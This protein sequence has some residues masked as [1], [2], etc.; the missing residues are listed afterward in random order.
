[1]AVCVNCGMS[2]GE[3]T[4]FCP[5]CGSPVG[6]QSETAAPTGVP[7]TRPRTSPQSPTDYSPAGPPAGSQGG[8]SA[9]D[10]AAQ[11]K[12]SIRLGA[13][14]VAI[15]V[16]VILL[17]VLNPFGCG[18]DKSPSANPDVT[19]GSSPAVTE[20]PSQTPTGSSS[21]SASPTPT[22][23]PARDAEV[24]SGADAIVKGI[25]AYFASM[26]VYPPNSTIVPGGS[27]EDYLP[28]SAWPAN[29]YTG[30]AM[31]SGGGFGNFTYTLN[32]DGSDYQLLANLGD[33]TAYVA[34]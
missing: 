11:K 8:S 10:D 29:P 2:F 28:T 16:I 23:D 34:H 5:A 9:P 31:N 14:A 20:S 25:D 30:A 24:R 22:V 13:I 1:M 6:A 19:P 12:L 7:P 15:V 21:P 32:V 27:L 26:G 4:Q 33:G 17:V 18:G 3:R